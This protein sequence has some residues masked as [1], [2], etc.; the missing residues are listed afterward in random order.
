VNRS[1]SG[2]ANQPILGKL[3]LEYDRNYRKN[4]QVQ[5][6]WFTGKF[7][8]DNVRPYSPFFLGLSGSQDYKKEIIFLD[9]SQRSKSLTAFV[10]QTDN[11]EGAFKNYLPVYADR[12]LSTINLSADLP[13]VP[14][15][16]YTDLG[17]ASF[18][19][20]PAT[21]GLPTELVRAKLYYGGGLSVT[22]GKLLQLYFPVAGS[23]FEHHFPAS[24]REFTRNI[25]FVFNLSAY[26]PFK[27]LTE[28]L[29]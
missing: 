25:R 29:K 23:N 1:I 13:A 5:V 7:F 18:N 6:R 9:R 26:D 2:T 11:R 27:Q 15:I 21:P 19:P 20:E 10:H 14:V 28:A 3:T 22:R 12:W 4:K 16:L 24:F 17:L 8:G